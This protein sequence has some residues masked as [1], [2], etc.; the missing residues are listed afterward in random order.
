[1]QDEE[2]NTITATDDAIPHFAAGHRHEALAGLLCT[3][4][5]MQ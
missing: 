2:G 3:T 5:D 1:M 4:R